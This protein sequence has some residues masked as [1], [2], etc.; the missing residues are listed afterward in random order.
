MSFPADQVQELKL[1]APG[2]SSCEEGGY[3]YF[4]LSSFPLPV[5]CHPE[6]TDLL[7]CPMPRDG[8][9]SRLYFADHMSCRASL[10]WNGTVRV[11]ER[12]WQAFSWQI[13][14]TDLRLAQMVL[15]HL[16]ALQ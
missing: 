10:N 9:T 8:Y 3:T 11:L 1:L 6:Q 14:Q 13:N 4:L 5:G 7:L 16:R 15:T 2:L 12:N